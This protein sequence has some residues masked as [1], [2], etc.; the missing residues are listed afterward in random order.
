MKNERLI[1]VKKA[2]NNAKEYLFGEY[3]FREWAVIMVKMIAIL[4]LIW[5]IIVTFFIGF[6][7]WLEKIIF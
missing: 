4:A 2:L 1:R 3:K 7:S 6:V 5:A